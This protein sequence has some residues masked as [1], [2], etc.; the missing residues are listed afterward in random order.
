MLEGTFKQKLKKR[1][2]ERFPGCQIVFLSPENFQGIPDIAIFFKDK[3]AMLE[4]KKSKDASVRPN[5]EHWVNEFNKMSYA[6]FIYPENMEVV[7]DELEQA[8]RC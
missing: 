7:L 8:F 3:W 1:I 2:E 6:S 5:Q 4:G